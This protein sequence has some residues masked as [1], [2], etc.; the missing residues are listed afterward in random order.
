MYFIY[1]KSNRND[2]LHN[3]LAYMKLD[4]VFTNTQASQDSI[5]KIKGA[6][7]LFRFSLLKKTNTTNMI[8]DRFN[9]FHNTVENSE[10]S[11]FI[12]V[13]IRDSIDE[14]SSQNIVKI[15]TIKI[16]TSI[17]FEL[18]PGMKYAIQIERNIIIIQ[19]KSLRLITFHIIF[20]VSLLFFVISLIAIE[21]NHKSAKKEKIQR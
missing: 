12:F 8:S 17:R 2:I 18:Y 3:L 9:I 14:F 19:S 6:S 13:C 4:S 10:N 7:I 20:S 16:E 15:D 5:I 21:Y 11:I 1:S